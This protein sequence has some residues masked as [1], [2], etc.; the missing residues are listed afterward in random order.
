M[1]ISLFFREA[2]LNSKTGQAIFG[3]F[4]SFSFYKSSTVKQAF[5]ELKKC[6]LNTLMLVINQLLSI[7]R[8]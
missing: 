1:L 6:V 5:Q 8:L 4:C 2:V 7:R 3:N